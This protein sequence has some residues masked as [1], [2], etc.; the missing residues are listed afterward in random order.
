MSA[1]MVLSSTLTWDKCELCG[2]LL[3][4]NTTS[5]TI[6]KHNPLHIKE[7]SPYN[8]P[9]TENIKYLKVNYHLRDSISN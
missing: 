2:K 1:D 9:L 3:Y 7:C 5:D 6:R 4:H 8:V